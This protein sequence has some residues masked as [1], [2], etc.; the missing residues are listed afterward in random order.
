MRIMLL[1]A[2]VALTMGCGSAD[3]ESGQ[4]APGRHP[5]GSAGEL[6]VPGSAADRFPPRPVPEHYIAYRTPVPVICDGRLDDAVWGLVPWSNYFTDI[7]GAAKPEPWYKTRLKMVWDD[8]YLY[9][10]AWLEEPHVRASLTQRDTVIFYDN[11]FEVFIDPDDD[12]HGYYE[13]EINALGTVWDLLLVRPYRDG[14][15]AVNNW[16]ISALKSGVHVDGTINN[17]SDIDRGW[18]VEIALPLRVMSECTMSR[19]PAGAGDRWRINFSR[20][21]WRTHVADGA[22]VKDIDP[23]TGRTLPEENWVWSPQGRVNM[24]MPEMWG[25]LQFS[26][27]EAGSGTEQFVADEDADLRWALRVIYYAQREYYMKHGRYAGSLR[28]LGL[29]ASD[30]PDGFGKPVIEATTTTF[31]CRYKNKPLTIWHDGR[32]AGEFRMP[33]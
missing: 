24:H 25:W 1:S 9:I 6:S 16:D 29:K 23:A 30:L 3:H 28:K 15:P 31:E 17:P 22:Y 32:I 27:I 5:S 33:R 7:E 21:E 2:L 18:S 20:V 12:T 11:D 10:G 13:L 19:Q 14:G 4:N 26:A 8:T